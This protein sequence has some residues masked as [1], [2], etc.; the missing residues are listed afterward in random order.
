M[1]PS[2]LLKTI[3]ATLLELAVN[4]SL[5]VGELYVL[6]LSE[7]F[8]LDDTL[9]VVSVGKQDWTL[10]RQIPLTRAYP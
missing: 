2:D 3:A 9:L 10:D 1:K 5:P 7:G 8:D 4:R 6:M